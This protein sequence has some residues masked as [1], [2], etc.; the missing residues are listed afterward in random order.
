M[1]K[2]ILTLSPEDLENIQLKM[3]TYARD[4]KILRRLRCIVMRYEGKTLTQIM[5]VLQVSPDSIAEWCKQYL[6]EWL[7]ALCWFKYDGRRLSTLAPYKK[8]IEN[9]VDANIYNTY[10]ELFDAVE[11]AVGM[12][13]WIKWDAFVK[14]CKKNSVWLQRSADSNQGNAQKRTSKKLW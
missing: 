5:K 11:K 7:D 2:I 12:S 10:A 1:A 9:L 6:S 3:H 14:F 13:L 8:T 4:W